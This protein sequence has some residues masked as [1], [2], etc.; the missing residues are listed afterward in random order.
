[1]YFDEVNQ[2]LEDCDSFIQSGRSSNLDWRF[3][4][5]ETNNFQS[6]RFEKSIKY[7]VGD[8]AVAVSKS[9]ERN[10]I[11][12]GIAFESDQ[13]EQSFRRDFASVGFRTVIDGYTKKP[14]TKYK[15]VCG[16]GDIIKVFNNAQ[17][18][19]IGTFLRLLDRQFVHVHVSSSNAF[20]HSVI[21]QI[22]EKLAWILG[23][24]DKG[25]KYGEYIS[26]IQDMLYDLVR[27]NKTWF[28]MTL[29]ECGYPD[30]VSAQNI[31]KFCDTVER[32]ISDN[33]DKILY[34]Y[35]YKCDLD[36]WYLTCRLLRHAAMQCMLLADTFDARLR[37]GSG[38][39]HIVES[40]SEF[41]WFPCL[42][43]F[44][45]SVHFFDYNAVV[46]NQWDAFFPKGTIS[47]GIWEHSAND[48]LIQAS[49][50]W[51]GLY[52]RYELLIDEILFGEVLPNYVI[53]QEA[54]ATDHIL[55]QVSTAYLIEQKKLKKQFK[56][57][58][59]P[60]LYDLALKKLEEKLFLEVGDYIRES[61]QPHVDGAIC[62]AAENLLH[63]LSEAGRENIQ[64]MSELIVKSSSAEQRMYRVEESQLI[65]KLRIELIKKLASM[66]L[67]ESAFQ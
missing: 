59:N 27:N 37:I 15:Q 23:T 36:S 48:L 55:R 44:P 56:Q 32:Y 43:L 2:V 53:D 40:L 67:S 50:I 54:R 45:H 58:K 5:D 13:V 35:P 9:L 22:I 49:D 46:K 60:I 57:H 20:Y 39:N 33:G 34:G 7:G 29:K 26:N 17:A 1:M 38:T 42:C 61:T 18:P 25:I 41:Y 64:L 65:T 47:N 4:Y 62:K 30:M 66:E 24:K 16:G 3:Y 63:K 6:L 52:S 11:I 19:G 14:E 10:F 51:V 31:K 12:G 8:E 21:S 28:M